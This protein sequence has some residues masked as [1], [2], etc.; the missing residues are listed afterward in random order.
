MNKL[1][2]AKNLYALSL[3]LFL[4]LF[5]LGAQAQA[6]HNNNPAQRKTS[7]IDTALIKR[8]TGIRGTSNGGE[9]KITV[10][11][12]DLSVEVD[13]FK[14][15]P[16]MGLGTWIAFT[17]TAEGVMMV[18]DIVVT[19]TDLGPVQQGII[20]QGLSITAI[21]NHF[22]RNR[23]NI[24]YMHLGGAGGT[25]AMAQKAKAV[26]DKVRGKDLAQG[27][28]SNETVTNILN[29]GQLDTLLGHKAEMN[30]G[31]Y[32]YTIGR[33]DVRLTEYGVPVS[34]FLGFNTWA[35]F[36]GTPD[37]TAVAGDFVMLESEVA[38]VVKALVEHGIEVVALH[39][40]MVHERPRT[41]FLHY[42]GVGK[43]EQLEKESG[44]HWSR[45]ERS[46][47]P[48]IEG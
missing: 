15:I 39:N 23:P 24:M 3:A 28:A 5:T 4:F 38:P 26:L 35:A 11:Q 32:R 25:E 21:H 14:I 37:R 7:P 48:G 20:P 47:R 19:E 44:A 10:P 43:A 22:I 2:Q 34:S 9:Y 46:R 29:T 6:G 42:W 30:K 45:R 31:V 17:P 16:A 1:H 36:Q 40:H 27:T 41:F 13:G 33:P 18:G 12:H 8:I